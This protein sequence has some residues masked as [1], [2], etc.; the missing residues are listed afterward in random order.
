MSNVCEHMMLEKLIL[1]AVRHMKG[2]SSSHEEFKIN[3]LINW[4]VF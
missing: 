2:Y 4:Q 1:M 3:L